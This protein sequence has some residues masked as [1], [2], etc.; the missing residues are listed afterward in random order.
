MLTNWHGRGNLLINNENL[1]LIPESRHREERTVRLPPL[2]ADQWDDAVDE[3]L[4]VMLPAERRN[5][6]AAGNLLATLARHPKLTKAF[7]RFNLH[8]LFS[9]SLSPRLREL[10]ILRV[11]HL[12]G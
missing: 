1:I 4:S 9:S 6:E 5:P 11:A 7:L 3:S 12:T 8:L 2:P 10:A